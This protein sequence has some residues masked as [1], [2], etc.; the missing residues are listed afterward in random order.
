MGLLNLTR[1]ITMDNRPGDMSSRS[2][3]SPLS[4]RNLISPLL[5]WRPGVALSIPAAAIYE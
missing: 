5:P 2:S 3:V 1:P 4:L